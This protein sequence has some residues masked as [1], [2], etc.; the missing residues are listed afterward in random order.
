[1][2]WRFPIQHTLL[3]ALTTVVK[4]S[5]SGCFA[6]PVRSD[7]LKRFRKALTSSLSAWKLAGKTLE[8]VSNKL[9]GSR[10]RKSFLGG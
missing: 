5:S 6:I 8:L 10:E 2:R 9:E 4:N 3:D 1:M 7:G